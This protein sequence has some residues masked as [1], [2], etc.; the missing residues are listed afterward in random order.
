MR[1]FS[2]KFFFRQLSMIAVVLGGSCP[3]WSSPGGSSPRTKGN[4]VMSDPDRAEVTKVV[5]AGTMSPAK[6]KWVAHGPV[7]KITLA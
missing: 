5:P 6:T 2:D 7:L 1:F 4:R 3:R